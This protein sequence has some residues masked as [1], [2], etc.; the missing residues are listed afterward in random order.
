MP[1]IEGR[2]F[3]VMFY[4]TQMA[5]LLHDNFVLDMLGELEPELT[6]TYRKQMLSVMWK[7]AHEH[8]G[9][10]LPQAILKGGKLCDAGLSGTGFTDL[11]SVELRGT[12]AY[13]C[14]SEY[15]VMI[16][17]MLHSGFGGNLVLFKEQLIVRDPNCCLIGLT[18]G[19]TV[20]QAPIVCSQDGFEGCQV[21]V[22]EF[23]RAEYDRLMLE[24]SRPKVQAKTSAKKLAIKEPSAES[25]KATYI[26]D[27]VRKCSVCH[28]EECVCGTATAAE[29]TMEVDA[30]ALGEE[31]QQ[32]WKWMV[33]GQKTAS[34]IDISGMT[35]V[36]ADNEKGPQ[37]LASSGLPFCGLMALVAPSNTGKTVWMLNYYQQFYKDY[38]A[39]YLTG[40]DRTNDKFEALGIEVVNIDSKEHL[41]EVSQPKITC[42]SE[43]VLLRCMKTSEI[44]RLHQPLTS[45]ISLFWMMSL[46]TSPKT[47]G[48][49]TCSRT[50]T[51]LVKTK[52]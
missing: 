34:G 13:E 10:A 52:S 2:Q 40:T 29:G 3:R 21:L 30:E 1:E 46:N 28:C 4:D 5:H 36:A 48:Q 45:T 47:L 31:Q 12:K 6:M 35:A 18:K 25:S 32:L 11:I 33:Y 23:D 17:F 19:Q 24:Q 51:G 27:G 37:V 7:A 38:K 44:I 41:Q 39:Y 9:D 16:V 20:V 8:F 43:R 49:K 22:A 15:A 14:K 50:D 42:E 26:H